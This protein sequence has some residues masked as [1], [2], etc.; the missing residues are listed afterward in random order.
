[1]FPFIKFPGV[2]AGLGP[3][4]KSTGEVMGID[5]DFRTAYLKAQIAAGSP[6]PASG[7]VFV[8]VKNADKRVVMPLVSHL[9]DLGF[10]LVATPGTAQALERQGMTAEVVRKVAEREG[11]NIV[12]LMK[13]GEIALVINTPEDGRARKDSVAI[14]SNAIALGIP[15]YLT[16]DG[17]QAAIGAIDVQRKKQREVLSLQEAHARG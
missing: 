5:R 3:E 1:V 9:V 6:L 7:K 2:D 17:A 14:R 13:R 4:M 12:D 8:S 15:Y 11:L 16:V 10:T